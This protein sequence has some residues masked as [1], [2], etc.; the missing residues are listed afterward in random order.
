[1]GSF[2]QISPTNHGWGFGYGF[3]SN[4]RICLEQ[5]IVHFLEKRRTIPYI[6]WAKTT[7]VEGFDPF[8]SKVC[9]SNENPFDWW[10]EQTIPANGDH[11]VQCTHGPIPELIDHAQHY[12]HNK[13][14]L[15]LQQHVDRY[16]IRPKKYITDQVEDIYNKEFKGE[17]VLGIMARGSEYNA[18]HPMYGVFGIERY[19]L[20]IKKV[21]EKLKDVTKLYIVSDETDFI[22]KLHQ[23][24][25]NSYF[26][27]NVFRRTDETEEYIT[28]VHC[29]MNVS[30]KRN[31]HTKKLG[32]ECIIQTKLLGKCDYL[33]GRHCGLTAGAVLWNENIKDIFIIK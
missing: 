11:V 18:C 24:F 10:F 32:E 33:C 7:W 8:K 25:P 3:F 9:T 1:M 20:E 12:F 2:Y 16:C 6:N 15:G 29:W 23:A 22:N 4:Y 31:P 5:L 14:S 26:V 13:A 30:E 21:L 17:V 19:I 28:R 27:P